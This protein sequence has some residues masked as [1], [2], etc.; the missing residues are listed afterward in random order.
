MNITLTDT[1]LAGLAFATAKRNAAN[2]N[3]AA[4]TDEEFAA[5]LLAV[6]CDG[7]AATKTTADLEAMAQDDALMAAGLKAMTVSPEKKSSAIAAFE[8]ALLMPAPKNQ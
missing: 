7:F 8:A 1:Q 6:Q 2:P 3:A 5:D 4:M